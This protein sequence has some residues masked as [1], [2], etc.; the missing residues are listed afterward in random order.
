MTGL[1]DT[2]IVVGDVGCEDAAADELLLERLRR[3]A[4][5]SRRV[6]AE[7]TGAYVLAAAGLLK[8]RRVTAHWGGDNQLAERHPT[9]IITTA[10]VSAGV[11][12]ALYLTYLIAGEDAARAI[13]LAVEYAPDPPFDSGN[14]ADTQLK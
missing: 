1:L 11:D 4:G 7:C 9:V 10:G 14:A 3:L 13:R 12:M 2:L 8:H 5:C 6:A